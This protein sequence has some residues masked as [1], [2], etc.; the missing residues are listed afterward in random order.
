MG[1]GVWMDF[2]TTDGPDPLVGLGDTLYMHLVGIPIA[3]GLLA[4]NEIFLDENGDPKFVKLATAK[5]I[6]PEGSPLQQPSITLFGVSGVFGGEP[7][8]VPSSGDPPPGADTAQV[9]G[10]FTLPTDRDVDGRIDEFDNC[11]FIDNYF[12][13]DSGR[14]ERFD[15]PVGLE[16]EG[17]DGIGDVC[18]CGGARVTGRV[19]LAQDGPELQ[20]LIV[21]QTPI[22]PEAES[23]G[24]VAASTEVDLLDWV[25]LNLATNGQGPGV[26]QSCARAAPQGGGIDN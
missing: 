9:Q 1:D 20:K 10:A 23:F 19:V 11:K 4:L 8:F 15:D 18:Q 14:V 13:T 21:G 22:E 17:A 6:R 7:L 26:N 2:S 12:Q 3:G 5:Y 25:V 24:S 16:G